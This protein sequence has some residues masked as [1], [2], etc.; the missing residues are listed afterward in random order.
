MFCLF[1]VS[2]LYSSFFVFPGGD[3]AVILDEVV[4]RISGFLYIEVR[5]WG[6]DQENVFQPTSINITKEIDAFQVNLFYSSLR[7]S[8]KVSF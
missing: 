6:D 4:V 3:V 5:K 1:V 2:C 7:I 8:L